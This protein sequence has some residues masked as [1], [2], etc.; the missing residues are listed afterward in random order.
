MPTNMLTDSAPMMASVL[1]ALR[2]LGLRNAGTPLLIASTPVSAV[3]PDANARRSRNR[4]SKPPTCAVAV[5][6]LAG[7]R[8]RRQGARQPALIA[9]TANIR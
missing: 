3:Q 9:P 2:A 7:G 5:Q 8:R 4:V 6:L 1:A